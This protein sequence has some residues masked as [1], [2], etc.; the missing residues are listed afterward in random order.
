M[1]RPFNN[2]I[3][4]NNAPWIRAH[5]NVNIKHRYGFCALELYF[6]DV[7]CRVCV[8]FCVHLSFNFKWILLIAMLNVEYLIANIVRSHMCQWKKHDRLI[9][10]NTKYWNLKCV[11]IGKLTNYYYYFWWRKRINYFFTF[12]FFQ[13]NSLQLVRKQRDTSIHNQSSF[14]D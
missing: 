1:A 13:V 3:L 10:A 6:I 9:Y 12:F 8:P 7:S 2:L 5:N 4:F 14:N 11:E